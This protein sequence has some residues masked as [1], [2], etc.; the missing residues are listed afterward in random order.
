LPELPS[1]TVSFLFT[2]VEGSTR[3][4]QQLREGYGDVLAD[5]HRLLRAAFEQSGGQETGTEGDAF[6]VAFRRARDAVAAAAA[7]QR[8]LAAHP[9]PEG[10]E[11]RVRMGIHTGEPSM[12]DEG[13][14]GMAL[15]RAARI[16]SAG[17]GGQVLLSNATR[18]LVEDDLPPGLG[19]RDLGERRLKDL[20]RPERIFQLT[21]DGLRND[22][23]PLK[24]LAAAPPAGLVAKGRSVLRRRG[25]LAALLAAVAAAVAIPIF[26]LGGESSGVVVSPNS[27]AVIDPDTN[28]VVDAIAV[29]AR[30][31]A[32]TFGSKALWV[33]NVDDRSVS[34]IDVATRRAE[35]AIAVDEATTGLA[36]GSGAVWG[37]SATPTRSVAT[38]RRID[39]DFN[40]V[41][42]TVE[43][44]GSSPGG[45]VGGAV[46]VGEGSVWAVTGGLAQLARI[47]ART[48]KTV[49]RI[50]AGELPAGVAVGGGAVWVTDVYAD[51]V[52]RVDPKTNLVGETI[53]V[54]RGPTAIAYGAGAVW[55]AASLDD[56]VVRIDP[57][58]NAPT[59]R[60]AVG[61]LPAGIAVGE[62]AVWV[63]NAGDG[64]VS[65]IDPKENTVVRTIDT[66]GSPGGVAVAAGLV[67][68]TVRASESPGLAAARGTA[69]LEALS[70]A[71]TLDPALAVDP[72]SLQVEYATCAKLLN[73]PDKPLPAALRLEPE[74]AL[75]QPVVSAAGRTYTF[76][77]RP[78]F[79]FS[80]PSNETVTAGTFKYAIERSLSPTMRGPARGRLHEIV[81]AEAYEA[82]RASHIAG[83]QAQGS[84]LT[85]RLTE[86]TPDLP[87][88]LALP[89]F[90]AVPTNTPID[91]KGVRTVPSAG[92]YYVASYVP[93]QA[94]VLKRNPSYG[95]RRPHRLDEMRVAVSVAPE[96]SLV[97]IEAGRTDYALEGVPREAHARLSS[98]Y[99]P[100]SAAAK[101]GRQQYFV[102]P[103]LGVDF[104]MLNPRRR[105]FASARL[106]RAANY[107][108]D[109]DALAAND[110][111]TRGQPADHYLPP[112]MPG[113]GSGRVYPLSPDVAQARRLARGRGGPA[114]LYTCDLLTCRQLA[115]IVK[116]NLRT[117][118]IDVDVEEFPIPVFLARLTRRGEPFDIAIYGYHTDVADPGTFLAAMLALPVLD[119]RAYEPRLAA[120]G[121]LSGRSRDLAYG[122]LA[123]DLARDA[124]PLVA[125]AN[126][127]RQDFFSR[128][129]G[130]QIYNPLYG[131]DLAALCVRP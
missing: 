44:R 101:A 114:V 4:L 69:R 37:I 70:D 121:R 109:R 42:G 107:A 116:E 34:R 65:R 131:M 19:L 16:S 60:I 72:V 2:D 79:R 106:R 86:P 129:I 14:H 10:A 88:R 20:A 87:A 122:R 110:V 78:G 92:P 22:F 51:A 81:G 1:G 95:G 124:A 40:E 98:R 33:S 120:A 57:T 63:A 90:C 53:R 25:V 48:N 73:Y 118:G 27:V 46:A 123:D 39:P 97:D 31:G 7:A 6:F 112:G 28:R 108:V 84:K 38:V 68:V 15:H 47:D 100:G 125:F 12:G 113:F 77:I 128:R 115:Q 94:I 130:C 24:T 102:N 36:A 49:A 35:K 18:E 64:T 23:P 9:W 83:V 91:P 74:V 89:S 61:D 66:G 59:A 32:I 105:L 93:G 29:G 8:A 13:Y 71:G 56:S 21:I 76:T 104:L 127:V 117:I 85:I 54:G 5:H 43:V 58:T 67:W 96:Q 99:G 3:L 62:G 126:P 41:V 75:A 45:T 111:F 17:H 50:E 82:G 103:Q 80:P 26:A 11:V 55:V 52:T 30:P 119:P